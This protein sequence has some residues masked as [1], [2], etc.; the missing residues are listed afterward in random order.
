MSASRS[1]IAGGTIYPSRFVS[2]SAANTVIQGT[3]SLKQLAG[4]SQMGTKTPP[5]TDSN[6][7]AATT[8]DPVHVYGHDEN[9]VLELGGTVTAGQFIKPDANGCGVQVDLTATGLQ[10]IGAMAYEPGASGDFVKVR[11]FVQVGVT[12]DA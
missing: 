5:G 12:T 1:Y 8:N 7:Y 11:V 3:A 4:V 9:A 6:T 2:I 10:I